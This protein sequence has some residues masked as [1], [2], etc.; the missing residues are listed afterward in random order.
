MTKLL[1]EH[2]ADPH[3]QDNQGKS[4]LDLASMAPIY[5]VELKGS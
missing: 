2:G 3:V 1:L 4:P 5:Q